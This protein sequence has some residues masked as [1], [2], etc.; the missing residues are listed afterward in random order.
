MKYI[1]L[2]LFMGVSGFSF[3]DNITVR[4]LQDRNVTVSL[5]VNRIILI[6]STDLQAMDI[7][8]GDSYFSHIVGWGDTMQQFFPDIGDRYLEKYAF[9]Q[10]IPVL[11]KNAVNFNAESIIELMPDVVIARNRYYKHFQETGMLEKLD[12]SGIKVIFIDF[13]YNIYPNTIKSI[14]LLGELFAGTERAE[15]FNQWYQKQMQLISERLAQSADKP[16]LLIEKNAGLMGAD[17]CCSF[18]G[19]GTVGAIAELAGGRNLLENIAP[20]NGGEVS[21]ESVLSFDPDYY[22]LSGADWRKYNPDAKSIILG[23]NKSFSQAQAQLQFLAQRKGINTLN[24]VKNK[25]VIALYHG[26]YDSPLSILL[27]EALAKSLYPENFS[28][29]SADNELEYVHQQFLS[30]PANGVFWLKL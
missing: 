8:S 26:F 10:K 22:I 16:T 24:A 21:L 18:Y 9:L 28:D 27:I 13:R 14:K 2:L 15:K 3:A 11:G 30:V 12:H 19:T 6:N 7:V 5:P 4:D 25:N 29:L 20:A 1:F 23:Y 17:V